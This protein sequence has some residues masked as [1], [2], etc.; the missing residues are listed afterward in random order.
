MAAGVE[1]VE[2]NRLEGVHQV[3]GLDE[4]LDGVTQRSW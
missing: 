4:S 1:E 3:S 2:S